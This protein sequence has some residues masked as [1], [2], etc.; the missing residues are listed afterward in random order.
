MYI[1]ARLHKTNGTLI[2]RGENTLEKINI[3]N[4]I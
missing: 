4:N 2:F 3:V 1:T